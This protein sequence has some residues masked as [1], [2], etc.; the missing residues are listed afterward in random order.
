[1]K[2]R[3]SKK[4]KA[5]LQA[6]SALRPALVAGPAV[7]HP[8]N[9]NRRRGNQPLIFLPHNRTLVETLLPPLVVPEDENEEEQ[10]LHSDL[11]DI[12]L[13]DNAIAPE[14]D[15]NQQSDSRATVPEEVWMN[16]MIPRLVDVFMDVFWRTRSWG[17]MKALEELYPPICTCGYPGAPLTV[18]IMTFTDMED[19]TIM[20]CMCRPAAQQLLQRGAFACAPV[21]PGLA[22]DVRLLEFTMKLFVRIALNKSAMVGALQQHLE[23]LGFK[24]PSDDSM[25]RQFSSSLEWYSYMRHRA[26]AKVDDVLVAT[27]LSRPLE[28]PPQESPPPSPPETPTRPSFP[29]AGGHR[30][31]QM[32]PRQ[33]AAGGKKRKRDDTP[34][35]KNPF[36]DP[37][38]RTRPSD[39]LRERCPGCFGGDFKTLDAADVKVCVDACFT[40]KKRK[41]DPDPPKHHP[42]THFVS[43]DLSHRM[44]QYVDALR[45]TGPG[46]KKKKKAR[47]Q[48]V[49]DEDDKHIVGSDDEED[50]YER[51]DLPLPRS[52]LNSCEASFKA[53]DEKREKASTKLH[54]DTALM[55]L[56][57]RHDR[58][59]WIVNMHSAGEKQFYVLLLIETFF[60]HIP[61]GTSVGLLYDVACQLERSARKWGFLNRYLHR[62][63]FA[64]AVFHA[65]GHDWL[66]Q[67]L[68]HPWKR[69][70]FGFS[71]GEGCERFWHSIS[72]LIAHL[73]ISSYHHRLYTLDTQV[74]HADEAN[75]FGLAAWNRRRG[76]HSTTKRLEA[77]AVIEECGVAIEVLKEEWVKQVA[78]QTKPLARRSKNMAQKAVESILSLRDAVAIRKDQLAAC[79]KAA[80]EAIDEG[81]NDIIQETKA[82]K[83]TAAAELKKLEVRVKKKEQALGVDEKVQLAN[84]KL[85]KYHEL[86]MRCRTL[87]HRMRDRLRERK[88]ELTPL[89]RSARRQI[90]NDK[91]LGAHT[92][93]AIKKREPTIAKLYGEYNK[94][95]DQLA[96]MIKS[97]RAPKSAVA[98]QR[99]DPKTV[100]QLEVDDA[101]WQDVGLDDDLDGDGENDEWQTE[102][103]LWLANES[104]RKGIVAMLDLERADEEDRELAKERRSLQLWF[105]EEWEIVNEAM[106]AAENEGLRYCIHLRRERL[107]RLCAQWQRTIS[108]D[109]TLPPWGPTTDELL[110]VRL[111]QQTAGRGEDR[112]RGDVES[113]EE[114]GNGSDGDDEDFEMV[115]TFNIADVYRGM[116]GE[117]EDTDDEDE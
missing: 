2:P 20:P 51:A 30:A 83:K 28:G 79:E 88:F 93:S 14:D 78:A 53:A 26:E 116:Y 62:L 91:K 109:D 67:L 10:F 59:L 74:K 11:P 13:E 12:P 42:N 23:A 40:Q 94:T 44:E 106:E 69:K 21:R 49:E 92:R 47:V 76:L 15:E 55:A 65:F 29:R 64:V 17:K 31:P 82:A 33:Q 22:V 3:L 81:D 25:R 115:D 34:P 73:R 48:E 58:V 54:D 97:K 43:E 71:N 18:V 35:P 70:G 60:Q 104:V 6:R 32:P 105:S 110:N 114:S 7:P 19:V 89:E 56:L 102:P 107:L 66:C 50:G 46:D 68:Y 57:C 108:T 96:S 61:L 103:P 87:K 38:P 63:I 27:R 111:E 86:R 85:N 52:V 80:L 36:P 1:M 24:L 77:E 113:D 5:E 90:A 45:G 9:R 8:L 16:V 99:I 84:V 95:C 117:E 39:Y 98:P 75:L 41:S 4:Q 100:W 112:Y 101:I 72:H 37:Q